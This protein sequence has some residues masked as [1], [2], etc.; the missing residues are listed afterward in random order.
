LPLHASLTPAKLTPGRFAFSMDV[1]PSMS[2]TGEYGI[3]KKIATGASL[4]LFNHNDQVFIGKR[5]SFFDEM[6]TSYL[7][8]HIVYFFYDKTRDIPLDMSFLGG[9]MFTESRISIEAGV[10]LEVAI[11][12]EITARFNL[13]FGPRAGFELAWQVTPKFEACLD[14]AVATGVL[15]FRI[16][17]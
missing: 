1:L 10:L 11:M 3:T 4:G 8:S 2:F 16:Y 6:E 9:L 13:I 12:R 5:S 17:F 15:G 14:L 7:E